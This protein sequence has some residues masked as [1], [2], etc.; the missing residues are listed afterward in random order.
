MASIKSDFEGER[1]YSEL[2]I[3][4][5]EETHQVYRL[6]VPKQVY[7]AYQTEG[8][9]NDI[10][11]KIHDLKTDMEEAINVMIDNE[12]EFKEIARK[13]K[14]KRITDSEVNELIKNIVL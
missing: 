6:E 4:R 10:L 2:F 7:W 9:M 8:A 3:G 14:D 11:M 5:G 12:Q 1:K 13:K